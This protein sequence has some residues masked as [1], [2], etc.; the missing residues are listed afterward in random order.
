MIRLN[1]TIEKEQNRDLRIW[2]QSSLG[3]ELDRGRMQC[4]KALKGDIVSNKKWIKDTTTYYFL[5]PTEQY[6]CEHL[7]S[8]QALWIR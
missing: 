2:Y 5:G 3:N 7:N 4:V 6:E 1:E 8:A